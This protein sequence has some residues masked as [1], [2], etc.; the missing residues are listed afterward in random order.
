[1]EELYQ[2]YTTQGPSG[3]SDPAGTENLTL[4]RGSDRRK[5]SGAVTIIEE[6][7]ASE[8]CR[9]SLFLVF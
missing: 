7:F 9:G 1:M 2:G 8:I 4:Q 5:T 6:P 3:L